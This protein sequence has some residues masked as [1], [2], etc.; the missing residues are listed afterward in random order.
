MDQDGESYSSPTEPSP[1]HDGESESEPSES[2]GN[3]LFDWVTGA[4]DQADDVFSSLN[5]FDGEI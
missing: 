5:P 4:K 2:E 1:D 3:G